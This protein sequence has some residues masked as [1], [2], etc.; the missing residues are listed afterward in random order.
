MLARFGVVLGAALENLDRTGD[1]GEWITQL[2]RCVGDEVSFGELAAHLLGAVAD[3]G[4]D[5][6]LIGQGASLHRVGA[7]AYA[8]RRVGGEANLGGAAQVREQGLGGASSGVEEL[9][10]CAVGEADRAAVVDNHH[11]VGETI[12]DRRKL[13]AVS[14]KDA[15]ALFEGGAHRLQ[16]TGEVADLIRPGDL[17]GSVERSGRHL[18]GG[19]GKAGDAVGDGHC[20]EEAGEDAEQ[21]RADEGAVVGA[22]E[23]DGG[24]RD[25][26]DRREGAR[27]PEAHPDP[28]HEGLLTQNECGLHV[29]MRG[30]GAAV[31]RRLGFVGESGGC[32]HWSSSPPGMR[33]PRSRA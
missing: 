27:E 9:G 28:S 3:D 31:R 29:W 14:G 19:L 6:A 23:V 33:R 12:E 8:E 15:E 5:G 10:G 18:T 24:T 4:K 1:P 32:A 25:Q 7:V 26:A 30:A 22:E 13:V 16:G 11:R 21:D 20:N 2:M 17:E